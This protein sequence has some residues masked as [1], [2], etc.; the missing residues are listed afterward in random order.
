MNMEIH[1]IKADMDNFKKNEED[2]KS[3]SSTLPQNIGGTITQ[4]TIDNSACLIF[5]VNPG[6][7]IRSVILFSDILFDS[8]S[9]VSCPM[10]STTEVII[11]IFSSKN[12]E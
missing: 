10:K 7:V 9:Y 1:K 11:P 8:G 5:N 4:S 2:S 3:L 12:L 6:L